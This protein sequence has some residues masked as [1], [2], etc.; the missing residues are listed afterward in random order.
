MPNY[1][2][3]Y[4]QMVSDCEERESQLSE[5]ETDFIASI[6]EYLDDEHPLSQKQVET[7]E[8]IWEK[9]TKEPFRR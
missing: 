8:R 5:W 6:S 7:L 4:A 2:D 1:T 9:V 3:E